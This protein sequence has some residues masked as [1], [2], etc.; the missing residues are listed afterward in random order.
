MLVRLLMVLSVGWLNGLYGRARRAHG[1]A[2]GSMECLIGALA[3]GPMDLWPHG[4]GTG[5]KNPDDSQ[6]PDCAWMRACGRPQALSAGRARK[7][8]TRPGRRAVCADPAKAWTGGGGEWWEGGNAGRATGCLRRPGKGVNGGSG[9]G[10][11]WARTHPGRSAG[12]GAMARCGG[13]ACALVALKALWAPK[14]VPLADQDLLRPGHRIDSWS[15][16]GGQ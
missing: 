10:R 4:R 7:A 8:V 16:V 14:R 6:G 9:V 12:G 1:L 2:R 11:L 5:A 3:H 13:V 15:A